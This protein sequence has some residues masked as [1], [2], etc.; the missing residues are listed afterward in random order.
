[1]SFRGIVDR[2]WDE[3]PDDDV[4]PLSLDLMLRAAEIQAN[5][6]PATPEEK[7]IVA[8]YERRWANRSE[9][10]LLACLIEEL[11]ERMR[12]DTASVKPN[13]IELEL[14]RRLTEIEE[15]AAARRQ[16]G[17]RELP[18]SSAEEQQSRLTSDI[19]ANAQAPVQDVAPPMP[20]FPD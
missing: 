5:G 20:Q 11:E 3:E 13:K 15:K 4:P 8:D 10:D 6:G 17:L 18:S 7:A 1:M 14:Q 16:C 2:L 19:G 9:D 12:A